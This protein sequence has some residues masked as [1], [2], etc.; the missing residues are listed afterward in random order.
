MTR[1]GPGRYVRAMSNLLLTRREVEAR[2]GITKTTIYRLM[3]CEA[4]PT[5]IQVGPRA[6]RWPEAEIEAWIA[7]LPRSRGAGG[8]KA[9]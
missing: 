6:V 9:D 5:P 7:S 3:R 4:F 2:L 8:T 1:T